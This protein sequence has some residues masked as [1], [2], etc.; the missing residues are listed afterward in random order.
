MN[1]HVTINELKPTLVHVTSRDGEQHE[2][3]DNV[4]Y[5]K[6]QK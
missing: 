4:L 1:M 2:T 6:Y 5:F 3:H